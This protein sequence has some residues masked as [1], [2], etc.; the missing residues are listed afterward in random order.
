MV[1][2]DDLQQVIESQLAL[3]NNNPN[4]IRNLITCTIN[5]AID[6]KNNYLHIYQKTTIH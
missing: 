4:E 5:A 6:K 3:M 1:K 2:K